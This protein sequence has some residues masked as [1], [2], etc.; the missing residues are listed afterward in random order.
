MLCVVSSD[1]C[2]IFSAQNV[3]NTGVV[4]APLRSSKMHGELKSE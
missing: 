2:K 3:P 4:R 1:V